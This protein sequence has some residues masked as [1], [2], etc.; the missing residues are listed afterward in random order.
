VSLK[1]PDS[2]NL[3]KSF[4]AG[5]AKIRANGTY[6]TIMAKYGLSAK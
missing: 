6:A 4:N 3:L 1:Y 2:A 5:L